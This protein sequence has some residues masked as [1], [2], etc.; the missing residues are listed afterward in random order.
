MPGTWAKKFRAL[1]VMV[2]MMPLSSIVALSMRCEQST[3]N[4]RGLYFMA[5]AMISFSLCVH[6]WNQAD[7]SVEAGARSCAQLTPLLRMKD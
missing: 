6:I 5:K 2:G 4:N 7:S 1:G 3:E